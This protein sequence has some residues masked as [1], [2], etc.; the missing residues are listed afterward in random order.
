MN[1]LHEIAPSD[2]DLIGFALDEEPL[3][4][5]KQRHLEQCPTCQRRLA[6]Y[7]QANASLVGRF[8]RSQCPTTTELSLYSA[9]D[10]PAERRLIVANHVLECPLC[11]QEVEEARRFLRGASIEFPPPA[12][13]PHALVRRIFASLVKRP[14]LQLV[15]RSGAPDTTW[16]RQ[17]K[18]EAIDLSLHLSRT[19]N[20]EHMLLGI[21][22]SSNPAEDVEALEGVSAELY[23]APGPIGANGDKVTST[24]FLQTRVDDMGNIVFKPLPAGTY[25]M[26][27]RLPGR[28]IIIDNLTI[29]RT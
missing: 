20:G 4:D 13:A 27:V 22:T 3:A 29:E 18:A 9:D 2:E 24:P 11:M 21:L 23:R 26:V 15:V 8:Y 1:C 17:Y 14:Q 7:R 16:P 10:L 12:V 6:H 19:S 28:E 25:V 5:E